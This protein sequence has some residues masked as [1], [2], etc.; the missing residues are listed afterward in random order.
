MTIQ[1]YNY[2]Y[3]PTFILRRRESIINLLQKQYKNNS[4]NRFTVCDRQR[5]STKQLYT[6]RIDIGAYY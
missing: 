6:A 5:V 1:L 3:K 2:T 4:I